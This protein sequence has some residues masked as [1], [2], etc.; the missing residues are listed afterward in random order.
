M[1]GEGGKCEIRGG[2][3]TKRAAAASGGKSEQGSPAQ[4]GFAGAP[5]GAGSGK[6]ARAKPESLTMPQVLMENLLERTSDH[7]YFKDLRSCFIYLS[8]ALATRFGLSDPVEAVGKTDFDVFSEE[9]A[10]QAFADE[11]EI[12]RSGVPLVSREEKETWPDGSI[13]WVSSSKWPLRNEAGRIIGTFGISRDITLRKHA[14]EALQRAKDELELRVAERTAELSQAV[15]R[16]ESHDRARSEF[17][18][19]VSH[20]L[21]TPLASMRF[22]TRNL[23]LGVAGTL[24]DEAQ[25]RIAIL[26]QECIR[27]HRTVEDILDLSRI[28]AG[29]TTMSRVRMPLAELVRRS[30]GMLDAQAEARN[31]NLRLSVPDGL[32]F[33]ECDPA[34]MERV[35]VNVIGNAVK[36][37]PPGG[38]V[39]VSLE[40][41][42][43]PPAGLVLRVIDDGI[44]IAP[45]HLGKV[46]T[47]YYRTGEQV[48][49]TGLG[50]YLARQITELHG[51][52][53]DIASPPPGRNSGTMVCLQLPAVAPALL[54]IVGNT[55]AG[56][57][58]LLDEA[59]AH[60]YR[61]KAC[62]RFEEALEHLTRDSPDLVIVDTSLRGAGEE[63]PAQRLV[64]T[65]LRDVPI[66]VVAGIGMDPAVERGLRARGMPI[67]AR[68]CT[69]AEIL[70]TAETALFVRSMRD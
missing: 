55:D 18:A 5:E 60:G 12:I 64:D 56:R 50:L 8:K 46:T 33:V 10:R 61:V 27:M 29:I 2:P 41:E 52:R 45:H 58:G 19:N 69:D 16:L 30:V 39:E 31:M 7:V 68:P 51:G 25:Q 62:D 42:V 67:L 11:Q 4:A 17:V 13:T 21:K 1:N 20:E 54:L 34:K 63:D 66:L 43:G 37:T 44:G 9:H 65:P 15:A 35:Y 36:F 14:E 32:G 70:K 38:T 59:V 57:A 28:E 40:R 48:S 6:A 24:P 47:K 26:E 53:L 22:G 49:G 3:L 23:L